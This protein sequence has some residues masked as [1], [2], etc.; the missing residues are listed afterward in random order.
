MILNERTSTVYSSIS[1]PLIGFWGATASQVKDIYEAYTSLWAS[2]PNEAYARDV[3]DSLVAIALTE[4][5]ACP[6]AWLS[7]ELRFEAFAAATGDRKWA[8]LMDLTYGPN[9]K[10][11]RALDLYNE[12]VTREL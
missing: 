9:V 3:Y 4:D 1:Q 2:T 7:A 8:A 5:M 11:D 10:D 6:I 12:R